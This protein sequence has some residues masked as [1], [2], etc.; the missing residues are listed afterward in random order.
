MVLMNR[1]LLLLSNSEL[2]MNNLK[3]SLSVLFYLVKHHSEYKNVIIVNTVWLLF[4]DKWVR[5]PLYC[6]SAF[7]WLSHNIRKWIYISFTPAFYITF[8]LC[9]DQR[10]FLKLWSSFVS[11]SDIYQYLRET[12]SHLRTLVMGSRH[13]QK[14]LCHILLSY[15]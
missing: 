1:L 6:I 4:C 3:P 8:F 5:I 11:Y 12:A 2:Q 15:M 9:D 7:L 13:C 10:I 14:Q